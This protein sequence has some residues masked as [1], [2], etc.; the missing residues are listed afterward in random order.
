MSDSDFT[1][2]VNSI[3]SEMIPLIE[4][5]YGCD[6][7]SAIDMLYRSVIYTKLMDPETGLYYQSTLYVFELFK[8]EFS[9]I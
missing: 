7:T 6:R 2:M 5:H 3:S 8:E 9:K 1:Y 4:K